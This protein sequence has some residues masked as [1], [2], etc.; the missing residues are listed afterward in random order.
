[1]LSS[2][3]AKWL[4]KFNPVK[5]KLMHLRHNMD[6]KYHITQDGQKWNVEPVQH[7]KDLGV[8]TSCDLS[9][10]YQCTEAASKAS[11]VLGMVRRQFKVLDKESFLIIYKGFIRPHLE[12]AIQAWSPYLRR[13][14][15]C[16][17]KVQRRATKMVNGLR[18]LPYES[19]LKK[20]KLTSLEKRRQRGDVIEV[21]KILMGK[22]GVNPNRF[23]TLDKRAYSTRGHEL[24]LYTNR[25]R[26]ELRMNIFSQCVVSHWNN[27]PGTAVKAESVNSFNK[28]SSWMRY[29]NVT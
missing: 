14:I 10:S 23:F 24:K 1:M 11:R 7:E 8:L 6:R 9:T 20:L 29:P 18:I 5:C 3:S 27:L 4:L 16:L 26:L 19:R 28:S 12:Y 25:S 13:D 15:D 22:E 21:Y 17:E 2:W